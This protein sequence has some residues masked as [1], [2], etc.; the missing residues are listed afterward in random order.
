[1]GT[2]L[3]VAAEQ[4][5]FFT[6]DG[7]DDNSLSKSRTVDAVLVTKCD[8][9]ALSMVSLVPRRHG[10]EAWRVLKE[11]YEGTGGNRTAALLRGIFNPRA[12]WCKDEKNE[13]GD[14]GEMLSSWE[15]DVAQYRVAAGADLRQAV[16][17][18]IVMEHAAAAHFDLLKVVHGKS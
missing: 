1:M 4:W 3:D 9:K 18:A 12:R 13:G 10:L 17:M 6:H 2:H 8:G 11:E 7:L 15:T 5:S 16:W 14:D